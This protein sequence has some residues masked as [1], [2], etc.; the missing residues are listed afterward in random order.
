[1]KAP[2]DLSRN[3]ELKQKRGTSTI[4]IKYL[5]IKYSAVLTIKNTEDNS[6]N[7]RN[8]KQHNM[9]LTNRGTWN[10]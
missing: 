7:R 3:L 1:M 6:E 2:I 5:D 4:D 8:L 10:E 9:A